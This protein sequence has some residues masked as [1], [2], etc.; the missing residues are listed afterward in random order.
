MVSFRD[1][2][3]ERAD[4]AYSEKKREIEDRLAARAKRVC[5]SPP[6]NQKPQTAEQKRQLRKIDT[7]LNQNVNSVMQSCE[8]ALKLCLE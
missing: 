2:S 7:A 1:D 8:K 4:L 5:D 6:V 3:K